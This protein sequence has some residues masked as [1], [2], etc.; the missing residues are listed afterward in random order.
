MFYADY[1]Q[2]ETQEAQQRLLKIKQIEEST[3][4]PTE[5]TISQMKDI[6]KQ[7]SQALLLQKE[8]KNRLGS[9]TTF[10]STPTAPKEPISRLARAECSNLNRLVLGEGE[11]LRA[12][13]ARCR[14][15]E[16]Y[17]MLLAP[18]P[19]CPTSFHQCE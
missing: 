6:W 2:D 5:D 14:A 10:F 7:L 9:S 3:G 16:R 4:N 1:S 15:E 18:I 12:F 11:L 17:C 19:A 13:S 8:N